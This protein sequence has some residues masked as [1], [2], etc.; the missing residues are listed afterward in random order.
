MMPMATLSMAMNAGMSAY[1]TLCL[2]QWCG[3]C[4]TVSAFHRP[5]A[6]QLNFSCQPDVLATPKFG[7]WDNR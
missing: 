5:H 4:T 2:S 6:R 7:T 1:P 3:P